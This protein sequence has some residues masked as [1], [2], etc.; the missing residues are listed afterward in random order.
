MARAA[1][2]ASLAD[3]KIVHRFFLQL[4]LLFI[5]LNSS[6]GL[7]S[8]AWS[9]LNMLNSDRSNVVLGAAFVS[10]P[11]KPLPRIAF[12]VRKKTQAAARER[13]KML[14]VPVIE[15]RRRPGDGWE[16]RSSSI[17]KSVRSASSRSLKLKSG[18]PRSGGPAGGG[19]AGY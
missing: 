6:F 18:G 13:E 19:V 1:A 12:A 2:G 8:S 4:V 5:P 17:W 16:S 3:S 10:P 14:S 11:S 7:A 15:R 9:Y